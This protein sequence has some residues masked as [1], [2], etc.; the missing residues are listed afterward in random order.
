VRADTAER[1]AALDKKLGNYAVYFLVVMAVWLLVG[2]HVPSFSGWKAVVRM[3]GSE[4][5]F[6]RFLIAFLFL[7]FAGIV[8]D[9]NAL[10]HTVAGMVRLIKEHLGKKPPK[11]LDAIDILVDAAGKDGNPETRAKVVAR[12]TAM[13]GKDFGDDPEKWRAW[14]AEERPRLEAGERDSGPAA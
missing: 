11:G 10:R 8:K 12:L 14:W 9:K 6:Q 3:F 2:P 7:Y 13:T 4:A 1:E 5:A